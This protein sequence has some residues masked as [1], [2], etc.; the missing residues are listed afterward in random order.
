MRLADEVLKLG[1][2][3][4]VMVPEISLTPQTLSLFYRRY[5]GR[6]R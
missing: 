4:L 6:W 3:V 2:A 1:R 5:G